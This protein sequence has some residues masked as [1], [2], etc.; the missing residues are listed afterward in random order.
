[1]HATIF[2]IDTCDIRFIR[3]KHV[4]QPRYRRGKRTLLGA[5]I[6]RKPHGYGK[7]ARKPAGSTMY[8]LAVAAAVETVMESGGGIELSYI[9]IQFRVNS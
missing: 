4:R 3:F 1:M 7:Y 6:V 5:N 9:C 2:G 8:D